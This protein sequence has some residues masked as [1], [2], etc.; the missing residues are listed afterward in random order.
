[1]HFQQSVLSGFPINTAIGYR[2]AVFQAAQ[3]SGDVLTSAF[4]VAFNH[5]SNNRLVAVLDLLSN[6]LQYQWLQVRVFV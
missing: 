1:M 3:V 5:Q 2:F 6:I 4:Q